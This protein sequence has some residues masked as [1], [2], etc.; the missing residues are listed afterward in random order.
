[1]ASGETIESEVKESKDNVEVAVETE[2]QM[3]R[4]TETEM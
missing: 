1:M 4:E 2:T 3:E